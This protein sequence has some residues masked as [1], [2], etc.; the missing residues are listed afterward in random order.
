MNLHYAPALYDLADRLA[1]NI[2]PFLGVH[3]RMENVPVQNLAWCAASLVS[4]LHGLLKDDVT[5]EN[6]RHVW[7]ATDYPYV[8]LADADGAGFMSDKNG[9][10][11]RDEGDGRRERSPARH[12]TPKSSTFKVLTPEHDDAIA[13]LREAFQPGGDLDAWKL[14]DLSEQLRRYPY[15]E[16]RVG[17]DEELL[18]DSGVHGILDKLVVVQSQV[19]VGG[20]KECSKVSSFSKQ[21]VEARRTLFEADQGGIDIHNVIEYFGEW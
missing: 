10:G 17:I 15:V 5:G 4:V 14:S 3:W 1:D 16:G 12:G 9:D 19:F 8:S 21:V 11:D 20:S 6:L 18:G 2:G 7:L 13:V